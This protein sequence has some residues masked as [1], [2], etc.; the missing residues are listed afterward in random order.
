MIRQRAEV[1]LDEV[2]AVSVA[3]P[4]SSQEI[5]MPQRSL[6]RLSLSALVT[7]A[8][9]A[10]A[11]SSPEKP[12]PAARPPTSIALGFDALHRAMKQNAE[13]P[14]PQLIEAVRASYV[15]EFSSARHPP[16]AQLESSDVDLRFRAAQL[17]AALSLDTAFV[18][19]M[20]EALTELE[21][22]G[23]AAPRHYL[24]LHSV[25][26][27]TR[28][29]SAARALAQR[30]PEA[31]LEPIPELREA[32]P[33][34][35][36]QPSEWRVDPVEP[37]LTRHAVDLEPAQVIV[38]SHPNCHFSQN[39]AAALEA[40]PALRP[41]FAAHSRWLAPQDGAFSLAAHRQ[42]SR[43]HPSLPTSLTVDRAEWPALDSWDTPTFYFFQHGA[44]VATVAGW[45]KDGR[46]AELVAALQ[47]ISL[48]P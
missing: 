42:W 11:C 21:R 46:R 40:D 29:L 2:G 16:F 28:Q 27:A 18:R 24:Q 1:H 3:P 15:R 45:P 10:V 38:V 6:H 23:V 39:A 22:R 32:S 9:L 44:L 34:F 30:H 19:D 5:R 17:A 43:D 13:R 14:T 48:L 31:S 26:I 7:V 4:A 37:A 35:S 12:S 33:V 41:I 8:L 20:Q 25:L 36:G 47:K